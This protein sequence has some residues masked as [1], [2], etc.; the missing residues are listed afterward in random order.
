MLT[1]ES[2]RI[3]VWCQGLHA[4]ISLMSLVIATFLLC[5]I[6]V[7]TVASGFPLLSPLTKKQLIMRCIWQE[8]IVMLMMLTT[9]LL[10]SSASYLPYLRNKV[11]R[12]HHQVRDVVKVPCEWLCEYPQSWVTRQRRWPL[13]MD[14]RRL[15]PQ[16][17]QCIYTLADDDRC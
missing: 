15:R 11:Y 1:M 7:L 9:L 13:I 17:R 14:K 8:L 5:C 3:H 6:S 10:I 4:S 12:W 2:V 16:R